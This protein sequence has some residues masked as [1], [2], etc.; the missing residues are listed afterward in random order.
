MSGVKGNH[1]KTYFSVQ[2]FS[3]LSAKTCKRCG[4]GGGRGEKNICLLK[5]DELLL[6]P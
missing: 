6:M 4:G 5:I 3:G 1:T 2:D